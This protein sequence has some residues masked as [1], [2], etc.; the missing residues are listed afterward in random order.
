MAGFAET[1]I[2]K[3]PMAG[4]MYGE[5]VMESGWDNVKTIVNFLKLNLPC[6]FEA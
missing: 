5:K 2:I 6:W 4:L 1:C 3:R